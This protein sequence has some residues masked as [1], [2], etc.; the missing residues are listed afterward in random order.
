[1]T[2]KDKLYLLFVTIGVCLL[3]FA[4]QAKAHCGGNHS[5]NHPHCS[6]GGTSGGDQDPMFIADSLDLGTP[7]VDS[8]SLDP[9]DVI[10]FRQATVDLTQFVGENE[11]GVACNHGVRTGTLS[12]RPKSG[13]LPD[14]AVLK[15]GFRSELT[16]GAEAHHLLVM[17][18]Q[19]QEPLNYPPSAAGS[20]Q[21]LSL[22]YWEF[23]AENK[24]AQREDCAGA[25]SSVPDPD[26]PW[27]VTVTRK[28]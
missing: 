26:A 19:F 11:S 15:F 3:L 21:L 18:G 4:G 28:P 5:G 17:E 22:D 14:I 25:S 8:Y 24:R 16:S 12:T 10:V 1:M 7:P 23:A 9:G 13:E 27:T 20:E 6:G 2:T